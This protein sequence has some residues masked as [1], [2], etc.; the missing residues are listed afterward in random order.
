MEIGGGLVVAWV[1]LNETWDL[2]WSMCDYK[3]VT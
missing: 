2:E 1:G 3:S